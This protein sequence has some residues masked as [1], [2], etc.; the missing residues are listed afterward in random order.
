LSYQGTPESPSDR[1]GEPSN[2]HPVVI[3]STQYAA[4]G[5]IGAHEGSPW[6][7]P[8]D[9]CDRIDELVND[10]LANYPQ[11][12][13]YDFPVNRDE[14]PHC[15]REWHGLK[16]T[17]RMEEM[18][19]RGRFDES[20]R[21]SDDDSEVI[22]EGSEF[23][24]PMKCS[25]RVMTGRL[26]MTEHEIRQRGHALVMAAREAFYAQILARSMSTEVVER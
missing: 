8:V 13:G 2:G 10:Q 15:F 20:Y 7:K 23:I 4:G 3:G 25:V 1:A 24:G 16:I 21:Y 9:I 5:L 11:R 26:V 14:C 19:W 6:L 22:C 12:S 17:R 18:R